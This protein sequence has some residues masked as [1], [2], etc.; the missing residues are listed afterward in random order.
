MESTADT[1]LALERAALDRWGKGDPDGFLELAAPDVSTSTR[2][3]KGR[4]ATARS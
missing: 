2:F 3:K 1:I 4:C